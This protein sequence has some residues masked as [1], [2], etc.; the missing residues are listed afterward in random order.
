MIYRFLLTNP[1]PLISLFPFLFLMA[2]NTGQPPNDS[3]KNAPEA[4][5]IVAEKIMSPE[6]RDL[7]NKIAARALLQKIVDEN[8]SWPKEEFF[9][10]CS[11]TTGGLLTIIRK[12][13]ELKGIRFGS[14][15]TTESQFLNLYYNNNQLNFITY[16]KGEWLGEE[17]QMVQTIFYLSN[18]SVFHCL[19][20]R[21]KGLSDDIEQLIEQSDY[22]LIA[23]P[24]KL[25]D[26]ILQQ[27]QKFK[28]TTHKNI[29][30]NFCT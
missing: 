20:K 6:E 25:L 1:N 2:C 17:E 18:D 11:P 28:K 29:K 21:I 4:K 14:T 5:L 27:E 22:R 30:N 15:Q 7:Q 13:K 12:D 3:L 9:Y 26:S 16:E 23:P 19:Q 24:K 10:E 8:Q